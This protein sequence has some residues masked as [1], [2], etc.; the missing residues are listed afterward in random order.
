[1]RRE[2][3][4]RILRSILFLF[5]S[6]MIMFFGMLPDNFEGGGL[7]ISAVFY[8][9]TAAFILKRPGSVGII[10]NLLAATQY[11]LYNDEGLALGALTY[12]LFSLLLQETREYFAHQS[13]GIEVVAMSLIYFLSQLFKNFILSLFFTYHFPIWDLL[14]FTIIFAI[15]YAIFAM[16]ISGVL[17]RR[18]FEN[19]HSL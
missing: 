6:M 4:Q 1:M 16:L 9:W 17:G 2:D 19:S 13:F 14:K 7:Q 18:K 12:L 15:A 10:V 8:A 11:A 3:I 5:V